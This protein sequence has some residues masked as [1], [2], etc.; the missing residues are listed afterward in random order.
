VSQGSFSAYDY[1]TFMTEARLLVFLALALG[2]VPTYPWAST[3][4]G[5][6]GYM[7]AT[8]VICPTAQGPVIA[9]G[10][11]GGSLFEE[12]YPDLFLDEKLLANDLAENHRRVVEVH[13]AHA[14]AGTG[15]WGWSP[16]QSCECAYKEAGVACLGVG[17]GYPLGDVSAYS[18][19]LAARY[20]PVEAARALSNL[21]QLVPEAFDPAFGYCD[22]VSQDGT[23][24]CADLLSLD[25]GMELLGLAA[26]VCD[27]SG[28]PTVSR[29]LWAYLDAHG[30]GDVGRQ[31]MDSVTFPSRWA[32]VE[33]ICECADAGRETDALI[34]F[35]SAGQ[36]G[37][38][39][40]SMNGVVDGFEWVHPTPTLLVYDVTAPDSFAYFT[41]L[42]VNITGSKKPVP[43]GDY[44]AV[45]VRYDG[46][47]AIPC[48]FRIELKA[49]GAI[50]QSFVADVSRAEGSEAVAAFNGGLLESLD[51]IT[52]AVDHRLA[53]SCADGSAAGSFRIE[54]IELLCLPLDQ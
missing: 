27:L 9:I 4:P 17:G 21:A 24:H 44:N 11:W 25:K 5:A 36:G 46:G 37:G 18:L 26:V 38:G 31:L 41:V 23:K 49:G 13:E 48:Q 14:D 40:G 32:S 12:L 16:S 34:L 43:V 50:L 52:L 39:H 3:E 2:Q 53:S 51:E 20:A 19:C 47:S 22:S 10:S 33:P 42:S 29:H 30:A 45:R 15:L 1:G 7:D 6:V 28:E 35:G 54:G 8:P